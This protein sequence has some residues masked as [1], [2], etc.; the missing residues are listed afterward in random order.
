SIF[1]IYEKIASIYV[2]G[3][4]LKKLL[5]ELTLFRK[6]TYEALE[7]IDRRFHGNVRAK[8]LTNGG[9]LPTSVLMEYIMNANGLDSCH[10]PKEHWPIVTDDNF[11][12]A[13]PIYELSKKEISYLI[14]SLERGKIVSLAGFLGVTAD[15]LETT[16]G[17]GGSDL[18]AVFVSCL[19][20]SQYNV[21]TLLFKDMPIQSADPKIVKGQKTFDI[22]SL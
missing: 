21:E 10:V 22:A 17:R 13:M 19:L 4:L 11:E 1:K 15:G 5:S 7:S 3:K 12:N 18:T 14:E 9:E 16:L 8:V 20:K 2:K 6:Q